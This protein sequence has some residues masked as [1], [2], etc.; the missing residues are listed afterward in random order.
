MPP[1]PSF[2]DTSGR[3]YHRLPIFTMHYKPRPR[4]EEQN[5]RTLRNGTTG[6][7]NGNSMKI[8]EFIRNSLILIEFP[9]ELPVVL[10][11][12]VQDRPFSFPLPACPF[13]LSARP[14]F[15]PSPYL[16]GKSRTGLIL[17]AYLH[18]HSPYQ[19]SHVSFFPLACVVSPGL[20]L[21]FPL[22][23]MPM[24]LISAAMFYYFPLPAW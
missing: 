4:P 12:K 13:T 10:Q 15:I 3:Q 24:D 5:S 21:F 20:A 11:R 7:S 22:T 14:C 2:C 23:C 6:N 18:A 9:L 8:K 1:R 19:R 16:H 17:S